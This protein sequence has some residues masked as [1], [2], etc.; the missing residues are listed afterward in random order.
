MW[1]NNPPTK[2]NSRWYESDKVE[3]FAYIHSVSD[4]KLDRIYGNWIAM[5]S[6]EFKKECDREINRLDKAG[7]Y[8]IGKMK[9]ENCLD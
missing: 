2:R 8:D 4:E 9:P 7:M 3:F 1:L 5:E 6:P